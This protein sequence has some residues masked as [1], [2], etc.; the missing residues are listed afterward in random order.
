VVI[1][2]AMSDAIWVMPPQLRT[3]GSWA[4]VWSNRV[5]NMMNNSQE[6]N[7]LTFYHILPIIHAYIVGIP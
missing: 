4:R 1:T 6:K 5:D 7:Q 3:L 2:Y